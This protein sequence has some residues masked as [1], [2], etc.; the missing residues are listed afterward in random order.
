MAF[1]SNLFKRKTEAPEEK[2][3]EQVNPP[4]VDHL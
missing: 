4:K 3:P 2:K 1:F